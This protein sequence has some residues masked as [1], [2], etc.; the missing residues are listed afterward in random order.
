MAVF[1]H[2]Q[3][4]RES[5]SQLQSSRTLIGA[6]TTP[7]KLVVRLA[8]LGRRIIVQEGQEGIA[9]AALHLRDGMQQ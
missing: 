8:E 9:P 1:R 5:G 3:V 6:D 7:E 4:D 2:S